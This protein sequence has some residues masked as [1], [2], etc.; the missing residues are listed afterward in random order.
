M[1]RLDDLEAQVR[2]LEAADQPDLSLLEAAHDA[3]RQG[4]HDSDRESA[5]PGR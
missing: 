5:A 2:E 4:L 3:L 1:S